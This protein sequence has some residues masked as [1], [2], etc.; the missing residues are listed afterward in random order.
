MNWTDKLANWISGGEYYRAIYGED[1]AK[2]KADKF[3][4]ALANIAATSVTPES[5]GT[6]RRAVRIARE[7]LE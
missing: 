2:A 5:N 1:D 4:A 3:A 6:L 7:A